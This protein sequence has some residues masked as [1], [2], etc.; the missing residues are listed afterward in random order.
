MEGVVFDWYWV[1]VPLALLPVAAVSGWR[2]CSRKND[3]ER[4][5]APEYI[6]GLNYLLDQETDKAVEI[7]IKFFQVDTTTLET[8]V[9]LGNLFRRKGE[10][11]KAI[12][13]HSN[14]INRS[15][16]NEAAKAEAIYQLG[17]D[18]LHAGLLSN[19]EE[20]FKRLI[21]IGTPGTIKVGYKCLITIYEMEKS[22][23]QAIECARQLRKSGL[24][25]SQH[26]VHYYCE[27]A[28]KELSERNYGKAQKYLGKAKS[29][30]SSSVRVK[31]IQGDLA[32]EKGNNEKALACYSQ[33]FS[34]YNGYADILLPKIKKCFVPYNPSDYA[35]YV[36]NLSVKDMTVLFIVNY[37]QALFEANR[38][39]Q[40]EDFLFYLIEAKQ[41]PLQVLKIFMEEKLKGTNLFED[42][43][44]R[45]II[46]EINASLSSDY[47]YMCSKCGFKAYQLYWQCPSCHTWDSSDSIDLI[48]DD[49]SKDAP[50][51]MSEK[52][53]Q[54]GESEPT[55]SA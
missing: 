38:I 3:S 44:V 25:Y 4:T 49:K 36:R 20:V 50:A 54:S 42:R 23:H 26:I 31:I 34:D 13:I 18:Y 33:A 48:K 53:K 40:A 2:A 22:W 24:D 46:D 19:A 10:T 29:S 41:A 9:L 43:M 45:Q 5:I 7:F 16:L 47:F 15:H 55:Y 30:E 39:D 14:L 1:L 17:Q 27:L 11:E 52:H 8:H 21:N 32:R 6:K 35:D 37:I 51:A 28:E 12:R